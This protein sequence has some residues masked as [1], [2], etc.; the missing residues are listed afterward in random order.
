M[1]EDPPVNTPATAT[2]P[3]PRGS[4]G[5]VFR[6]FLKLGL[7]SFGGPIA[8]L[9]FFRDELVTRR[10]WVRESE[11][12][13]LVA[14]GQFLP[15]PASSQVGF[16]LGLFRAGPLGALAAW[17]AFTLPSAILLVAF[18]YG[19]TLFDN[20]IGAGVLAG[21][22]VVA[23]AIVA[24]AVWGMARTLTPDARR[25][26]I[27]V[28][29]A[30][31]VLFV[32]GPVGQ[33]GAIALGALAGYL[34]CRDAPAGLPTSAPAR[35]PASP[36]AAEPAEAEDS[37]ATGSPS[38]ANASSNTTTLRIP[39]SRRAGIVALSLFAAL[40]VALP[41][42]AAAL[43][44]PPS[45]STANPAGSSTANPAVNTAGSTAIHVA[46]SFYRA[47]AL[48]S[49]GGHVVLPLL[50]SEVVTG[51]P[52]GWV[53]PDAFLA[54]YGAAQAVPGPLF[55]FAAYLGALAEPGPAGLV[56]AAI[57][58][59]AVFLPGLL[60]LV[61]VLPFWNNFRTKRPAQAIM[62]GA[63]AAVVGILAAALYDPVFVT[64]IVDPATFALALV[65]FA[66]LVSWRTPP[67]VVV[68]VGAAGG[69]LLALL[70]LLTNS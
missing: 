68:L 60:L 48:V 51:N 38:A 18:A 8:H 3:A 40:L 53:T 67:W 20:A 61:G 6:A 1:R 59:V 24:Q 25:A 66:L 52:V 36:T 42:A 35:K 11:Y 62:R 50:Q 22:K 12:A 31:L 49:G 32:A 65:C 14:L 26:S 56:T 16:A 41:V 43:G 44:T 9:G 33:V 4:V 10:R 28:V 58:L 69:A 19:A 46:D 17:I 7:T 27:A 39:V 15:G 54:G 47:G 70:A 29:A 63:N 5:E 30:I 45:T 2:G 21:L 13:D 34:L 57:A 55:T 64:A 23:V 37:L